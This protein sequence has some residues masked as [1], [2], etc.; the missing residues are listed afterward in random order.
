MTDVGTDKPRRCP[1]CGT[2]PTLYIDED[3]GVGWR[4]VCFEPY[5]V[6][7]PKTPLCGSEKEAMFF[8]NSR[9]KSDK[10]SGA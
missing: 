10:W 2:P 3:T 5:C 4:M 9:K 7:R 6:I 8:W 1:F